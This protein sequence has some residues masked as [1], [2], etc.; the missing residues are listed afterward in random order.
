MVKQC[1]SCGLESLKVSLDY[2]AIYYEKLLEAYTATQTPIVSILFC[3]ILI[4]VCVA[5]SFIT[6]IFWKL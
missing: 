6:K 3:M 1:L 4:G 5:S 2:Y